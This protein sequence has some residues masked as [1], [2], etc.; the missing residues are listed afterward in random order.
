MKDF[1]IKKVISPSD[2]SKAVVGNK[3]YFADGLNILQCKKTVCQLACISSN[4]DFPFGTERENY[5]Y[6]YPCEEPE[7]KPE[8][9]YVPFTMAD[10]EGIIGR[11]VKNKN[12]GSMMMLTSMIIDSSD[13]C[14]GNGM[15]VKRLLADYVFLDGAPCGNEVEK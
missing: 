14:Y 2:V 12:T 1:D 3:Y 13:T 15:D 9:K 6:L 7:K 10:A 4:I 11:V 8:K 5:R